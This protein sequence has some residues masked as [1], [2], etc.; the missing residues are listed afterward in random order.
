MKDL[1]LIFDSKKTL[2]GYLMHWHRLSLDAALFFA[3]TGLTVFGFGVNSLS[4]DSNKVSA[5]VVLLLTTVLTLLL[6]IFGF[7]F[8]R[9]INNQL[10]LLRRCI[11]DLDEELGLFKEGALTS[12]ASIY[13]TAWRVSSEK[14]W[15]DPLFPV[16][17]GTMVALP[18]ALTIIQGV[19][20]LFRL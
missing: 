8:R 9:L 10:L 14:A 2:V 20:I 1:A 15:Q 4:L 16:T 7:Y 17:T 12:G 5:Q 11:Q 18:S 13:P 6:A 3:V 19:V